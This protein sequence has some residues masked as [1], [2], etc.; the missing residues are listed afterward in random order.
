M[1]SF[2][3]VT[4]A[5]FSFLLLVSCEGKSQTKVDSTTKK[6]A[7][8]N[9][10]TESTYKLEGFTKSCCSGIVEYALK[11]VDGYV[12]SKANVKNKELTVWF[13]N[14]KTSEYVIKQAINRTAYKIIE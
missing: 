12:K 7:I 9:K 4:I 2:K 1:K 5:I 13:D 11:E 10:I 8:K 3:I 14:T 6:E